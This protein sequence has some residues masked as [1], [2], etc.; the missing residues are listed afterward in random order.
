LRP[1][2]Y[3]YGQTQVT[4]PNGSELLAL[5]NYDAESIAR[6]HA[7]GYAGDVVAMTR[8]RDRFHALL[9]HALGLHES[10]ALRDATEDVVS[11]LGH[12]EECMVL[13]AQRFMN[14]AIACE[15][16]SR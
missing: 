15:R 12:A 7:L 13:A 4:L 1:V 10:P 16:A 3:Q 9:T 5:P 6:A 11:E 8:D 2:E 14:L